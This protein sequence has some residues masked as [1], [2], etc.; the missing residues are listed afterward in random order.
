MCWAGS[1][2][3]RANCHSVPTGYLVSLD[4]AVCCISAESVAEDEQG[5]AACEAG[6]ARKGG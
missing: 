1:N 3:R 4:H 5:V 6:G 2:T